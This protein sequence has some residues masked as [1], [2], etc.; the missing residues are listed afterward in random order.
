MTQSRRMSPD[1]IWAPDAVPR[2][3]Y[4]LQITSAFTLQDAAR[5]TE[6]VSLLGA[7][8][9]YCSPLLQSEPGS[10]HGYDVIDHARTDS[11]RGGSGGLAALA[12]SAHARGLGLMVDIVPNHVG[13]AS[14]LLSVWWRDLLTFGPA[15]QF[16]SAFDIDWAA[17]GGKVII[18]ILGDSDSDDDTAG[19]DDGELAA[20]TLGDNALHYYEHDFPLAPGSATSGDSA[21]AVHA[22]QHYRLVN[23]RLADTDLNYRR[24]FAVN[25][26]AAIRVEELSVFDA[27]HTEIRRWIESGWVD[28]LRVDHPDGLADPQGYLDSLTTLSGGR[29]TVVEKILEP[30]EELPETWACAGTTGYDALGLIDRVLVNPAGQAALDRLDCALRGASSEQSG[31]VW[32]EMAHD[33]KRAVAD[34]ILNSEV[35]RLARLLPEAGTASMAQNVDAIAELLA[36]FAVYRT[37]LADRDPEL[38]AALGRAVDHRP[39]L[40]GPLSHIAAAASDTAT[41]LSLRL[42]ETSGAVMAKGVEDCAFYRY[43]RLTS[44]TEVGGDPSIFA[45]T[46]GAFHTEQQRR[47]ADLQDSMTTLSTHDTKRGEDVRARIDVLAELADDWASAVTSWVRTLGFTDP[48]LANLLF[49]TAMGAWPIDAGR[50]HAYAEKAAREAG[51]ST[52]WIEPNSAFEQAMHALVDACY[53]GGAVHADLDGFAHRTRAAGWSNSLSA[54]LIQLTMPGV[55]DVYRGTELWS[56]DLVDP[57][58][59]RQFDALAPGGAADM[60]ARIDA[61]WLPPVDETGAAKLLVTSR[62]LRARRDRPDAFTGYEPVQATG[63]AALHVLA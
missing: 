50:L 34:G 51:N 33:T 57:D 48:V 28:G 27:S 41:E 60:L 59:R 45:V 40:A 2:S 38:P 53:E 26:L 7:D 35:R 30:G 16:A 44:L 62:S 15:S 23:F 36:N 20:L 55:P 58:N 12:D 37:Y 32:E 8:W 3:T 52:G 19:D 49:Q 14:P 5:W 61:G 1:G 18:P 54:K 6:Y 17:G 31:S 4:R 21:Q 39:D 24:F 22:R 10:N 47:N 29:Y 42:Q 63:S 56:S 43:P 13:I 9:L 46:P 11:A 25:T